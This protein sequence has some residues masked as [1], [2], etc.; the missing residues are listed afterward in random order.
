[1]RKP[2]LVFVVG[3]NAAGKSSFIRTRLDALQGFEVI[4]TDVYKGRTKEIFTQALTARKDIILETVFND[5][6]F[7]NLVDEARHAGYHTSLVVLFLDS[8]Q[9]SLERVAFRSIE[10]SGLIISG[11][12]IKIN[13]NESFKNVAT[14]FFYF[15]QSDF[16]YTGITGK[17]Q[18]IMS[19]QRSLLTYY[20]ENALQYPQKLADYGLLHE[21]LSPEVHLLIKTNET[22]KHSVNDVKENERRGS[23]RRFEI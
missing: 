2:E 4:M 8:P 11:N 23:K 22:Y 14:Y 20:Q 19:F 6:S 16:I 21:R 3:P 5:S 12:N 18:L 13:F 1:M 7:K 10:Q 17:N 15:D 9:H